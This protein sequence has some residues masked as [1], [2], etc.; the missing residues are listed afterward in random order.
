MSTTIDN[1]VVSM[2][3]DNAQFEKGIAQSQESLEKFNKS[4]KFDGAVD[5]TKNLSKALQDISTAPIDKLKVSFD[6][7]DV[8]AMTVIHRITNAFMDL[9][10]KLASFS[11]QNVT[12]GW[13][14]YNTETEA[15][16]TIMMATHKSIEEVTTALEKLK[17]YSDETSYSYSDMVSAISKFVSNGVELETAVTAVTGISNEAASAGGKIN[18]AAIAM[19]NLSQAIST[20]SVKMVDWRSIQLQNLATDDF[21]QNI[22]DVAHEMGTLSKNINKE[23]AFANLADGWFSKDVLIEVLRRYGEYSDA[24]YR[25][26]NE[27]GLET[28]SEA[29]AQMT[30][31][32][33]DFQVS[34]FKAAQEAKTFADAMGALKDVISTGW[35]ES[36]KII[37]GDY[38]E[39]KKF[40]TDWINTVIDAISPIIE[41]R[42]TMLQTWKD[43]GGR[44]YIV[45]GIFNFFEGFAN[46]T[47]YINKAMQ[48]LFPSVTSMT[49]KLAVYLLGFSRSFSN[50]SKGFKNWADTDGWKVSQIFASL[51]RSVKN[52]ANIFKM[53]IKPLKKFWQTLTT[54]TFNENGDHLFHTLRNITD[55]IED[56]TGKVEYMVAPFT[57]AFELIFSDQ[58]NS[59]FLE[60]IDKLTTRISEVTGKLPDMNDGTDKVKKNLIDI[61]TLVAGLYS[62]IDIAIYSVTTFISTLLNFNLGN[63]FNTGSNGGLFDTLLFIAL[64]LIKIRNNLKK[65][66]DVEKFALKFKA[67]IDTFF[68][69]AG[70]G[71][72][73]IAEKIIPALVGAFYTVYNFFSTHKEEIVNAISVVF[74]TIYTI[75]SGIIS[76]FSEHKDE[77]INGVSAFFQGVYTVFTAV[78]NFF[79]AH[80]DTLISIFNGIISAWQTFTGW[81]GGLFG[82]KTV[83][84]EPDIV[85]EESSDRRG[86]I[87]KGGGPGRQNRLLDD[88]EEETD[89]LNEQIVK[90]TDLGRGN[91]LFERI[92][93]QRERIS[94]HV[95]TYP[96]WIQNII[97]TLTNIKNKIG[98]VFKIL[99][100]RIRQNKQLK[101]LLETVSKY[102]ED[103]ITVIKKSALG[104][105]VRL[106]WYILKE[107]TKDIIDKSKEITTKLLMYKDVVLKIVEILGIIFVVALPLLLLV[108][109][110]HKLRKGLEK[111]F[112]TF[113]DLGAAFGSGLKSVG[114]GLQELAASNVA[115]SLT[116]FVLSLGALFLMIAATASI[117]ETIDPK[118]IA[119]TLI[120]V[121]ST[122]VVIS[123]LIIALVSIV[124]KSM[125]NVQSTLSK[126]IT[127]SAGIKTTEKFESDAGALIEGLKSIAL[128]MLTVALTIGSLFAGMI[129]ISK[130]ISEANNSDDIVMALW[131]AFA[132]IT[133]MLI[134]IIVI[135]TTISN[136]SEEGI[137]KEQFASIISY[138]LSATVLMTTLMGAYAGLSYVIHLTGDTSAETLVYTLG[139]LVG[140]FA[141]MAA[142]IYVL[143]QL[144]KEFDESKLSEVGQ[145]LLGVSALL[146][147]VGG[148]GTVIGLA[149]YKSGEN[150]LAL[151]GRIAAAFALMGFALIAIV[152]SIKLMSDSL[153]D[154]KDIPKISRMI[155]S[156]TGLLV[157]ITGITL[158]LTYVAE[159]Y[160]LKSL[161]TALAIMSGMILAL[162]VFF[163]AVMGLSSVK[164]VNTEKIAKMFNGMS[165]MMLSLTACLAAIAFMHNDPFLRGSMGPAL[166]ILAGMLL[167]LGLVMVSL[168]LLNRQKMVTSY[169]IE[170]IGKMFLKMGEAIA[171]ITGS[172]AILTL[173][174]KFD[175]D[176]LIKSSVIIEILITLLSGFMVASK[177]LT[178]ND[179]NVLDSFASLLIKFSVLILIISS[180]L[181]IMTVM[182]KYFSGDYYRNFIAAT[183]AILL[184]MGGIVGLMAATKLMFKDEMTDSP[185][186]GSLSIASDGMKQ[187]I[188]LIKM[189]TLFLGV[190]TIALSGLMV[191]INRFGID[192]FLFAT[193]AL[194]AIMGGIAGFMAASGLLIKK[195]EDTT[196]EETTNTKTTTSNKTLD[197]FN[198]FISL[199][200]TIMTIISV[201]S[202]SIMGL[203][204][205]MNMSEYGPRNFIMATVA[206]L[207]MMGAI[208]GFM[209]AVGL[210]GQNI[211]ETMSRENDS[212]IKHGKA[213][214]T[215]ETDTSKVIETDFEG[216]I[217]LLKTI[218]IYVP[219]ISA[220]LA[221]LSYV[222]SL[223]KDGMG[224]RDL[225]VSVAAILAL[226]GAG[227][228]VLSLFKVIDLDEAVIKRFSS[229][230]LSFAKFIGGVAVAMAVLIAAVVLAKSVGLSERI[231]LE[232][233]SIVGLLSLL[234]L[235]PA[236]LTRIASKIS[237]GAGDGTFDSVANMG[238]YILNFGLGLAMII[239][240]MTT[241][242]GVVILAQ[243]MGMDNPL[244]A[245][246]VI[247]G[248]TLVIGSLAALPILLTKLN[249]GK[250]SD[251]DI[252][253]IGV[254]IGMMG[255]AILEIMG[256]IGLLMHLASV[257]DNNELGKA[258]IAISAIMG[259][260]TIISAIASNADFSGDMIAVSVGFNLFASAIL[261]LGLAMM[262]ASKGIGMLLSYAQM[263]KDI[264]PSLP[265]VILAFAASLAPI[266]SFSDAGKNMLSLGFGMMF[267]AGGAYILF[268]ALGPFADDMPK[269]SAALETFMLTIAA[270][271]AVAKEKQ[272]GWLGFAM[273]FLGAGAGVMAGGLLLLGGVLVLFHDQIDNISSDMKKIFRT[274]KQFSDMGWQLF[275]LGLALLLTFGPGLNLV[276]V[277]LALIMGAIAGFD[278]LVGIDKLETAL[279]TL[280]DTLNDLIDRGWG[281]F[282]LGAALL[283]T[284]GPGLNLVALGLGGI[285][286]A[287]GLFDHFVGLDKLGTALTTLTDT[288]DKLVD[289]A[290]GMLGVGLVML[291]FFGPG[292]LL[293]SVAI[294]ILAAA[295]AIVLLALSALESTLEELPDKI[296]DFM[297]AL[298]DKTPE[299]EAAAERLL[300][301]LTNA[302]EQFF[303]SPAWQNFVEVCK[304]KA[305]ELGEAIGQ[306]IFDAAFPLV[307][308]IGNAFT[309][310]VNIN[311]VISAED[312]GEVVEV[313]PGIFAKKD[314]Y[315]D[316]HNTG[317]AMN[318]YE[319]KDDGSYGY[320]G[321]GMF[322]VGPR[323]AER[324]LDSNKNLNKTITDF[325]VPSLQNVS[326]NSDK[327]RSAMQK[328][329]V[330]GP[331]GQIMS[332][333][334]NKTDTQAAAENAA[335]RAGEDFKD[336]L[337]EL[338][339]DFSDTKDDILG[340]FWNE[341]G[342]FD[343]FAGIANGADILRGLGDSFGG[344]ADFF[345]DW[346]N[347][348]GLTAIK[349]LLLDKLGFEEGLDLSTLLGIDID[350]LFGTEGSMLDIFG[351][352]N[353]DYTA[354]MSSVVDFD[355]MNDYMSGINTSGLGVDSTGAN[356]T[357]ADMDSYLDAMGNYG[358][359][360]QNITFNQ[361]NN[362]PEPLSRLQIYRNTKNLL[363]GFVD[364]YGFYLRA[365]D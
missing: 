122:V 345:A 212:K 271:T 349:N 286:L 186:G 267:L 217:K 193:G 221:A 72:A 103:V 36:F 86:S 284:F 200:Q 219:I 47:E 119:W 319:L 202:V 52:I 125:S 355:N 211:T 333:D 16:Q 126:K 73:K 210:I 213:R 168:N 82:Q 28:A 279:D 159:K 6:A 246:G 250:T 235:L 337:E 347:E 226:M 361:I 292:L 198:N 255:F 87:I 263:A 283:L 62:A 178:N 293:V 113:I 33:D 145:L 83:V 183:S 176:A 249:N 19:Y 248:V 100:N 146:L 308:Q 320:A 112:N 189:L 121:I 163:T 272:I 327:Q 44:D 147:I 268:K 264:L 12:Q 2:K 149:L 245:L 179:P 109:K 205:M 197:N 335:D 104:Q 342:E 66:D 162:G 336:Y 344:A 67:A 265:P 138:V 107:S 341:N 95:M 316:L 356:L 111:A 4:L 330:Y 340:G 3:F 227:I 216:F 207:L 321:A 278:L 310:G 177:L 153:K 208:T 61:T 123:G 224:W 96:Q 127:E 31:E 7:L 150:Q 155:G 190:I 329:L 79:S 134:A 55:V 29:M 290:W 25:F 91:N 173:L 124:S 259:F 338:G 304:S 274:F 307:S 201:I 160:N 357:A 291:L 140:V 233:F 314:D 75:I 156:I 78:I 247:A 161:N 285:L 45:E 118:T 137:K 296:A 231:L 89:D 34:A 222:T 32:F 298:A 352:D 148:I 350:N 1:R 41:F 27:N 359:T 171:I 20:G 365:K 289:K 14:K 102:F 139:A 343:F 69:W 351:L 98:S 203:M 24:V 334:T 242:M 251:K 354:G 277:D 237:N 10:G 40:W 236:L 114:S 326:D 215:A 363:N 180:A 37:F 220:S 166:I 184:I 65:G 117:L 199:L 187:F 244:L 129:V 68:S 281:I 93:E 325:V 49:R 353:M 195:I 74:N 81:I 17:W 22:V 85:M 312:M 295:V 174:A 50:V 239:G 240:A 151:F 141:A 39:S 101:N 116:S 324:L 254:S 223:A 252:K 266:A 206:L 280:M 362:S 26:Q 241:L 322:A 306:A 204:A 209:A 51:M 315:E 130:I 80:K 11:L 128:V 57:K 273:I 64:N 58:R 346:K 313:A 108:I 120:L 38:E 21:K 135:A 106:F 164:E 88:I 30:E 54:K 70:S 56:L 232:V 294:L 214:Q 287:L 188:E 339:S 332:S 253:A 94:N 262:A 270:I 23:Q 15:V 261:I 305:S 63:L 136:L 97:D 60:V 99:K 318:T 59:P 154:I 43:L 158:A 276:A 46:I 194:L 218:M 358:D 192:K 142:F 165:V 309:P 288:I 302:G 260:F 144:T 243:K 167:T 191:V 348:G 301:A 282:G 303:D 323:N 131:A 172:L 133:A 364:E 185:S 13:A 35:G 258:M 157:I 18:Q 115:K 90:A 317:Y 257:S 311:T 225:L 299:I 300:E 234:S 169:H 269:L 230:I 48:T 275:G 76:F 256:A 328:G 181:S 53:A 228:A 238:N 84:P 92:E 42:N 5:G 8:V 105:W 152:Y 77:I 182:V 297:N 360:T 175:S 331:G 229:F 132:S 9:T 170:S 196:V 71:I 143:L 110:V